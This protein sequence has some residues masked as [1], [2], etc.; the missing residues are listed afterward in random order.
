VESVLYKTMKRAKQMIK[1]KLL[2][3]VMDQLIF[4]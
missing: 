1:R 2:D 3:Q 4:P